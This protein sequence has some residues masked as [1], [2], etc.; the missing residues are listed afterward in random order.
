MGVTP[1]LPVPARLPCKLC[2]R[3]AHPQ[4]MKCGCCGVVLHGEWET[5]Q[6]R[7]ARLIC[8]DCGP[9]LGL[10]DVRPPLPAEM[11]F[12]LARAIVVRIGIRQK[13]RPK[14]TQ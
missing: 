2:G 14:A 7:G 5:P 6:V 11:C 9:R 3:L 8:K 13:G 12:T 10:P 1:A 4:A